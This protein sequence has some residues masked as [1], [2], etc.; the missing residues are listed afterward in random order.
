M[1]WRWAE[2]RNPICRIHIAL[3]IYMDHFRCYVCLF[4]IFHK[5]S[6]LF[7]L[8]F[9]V[10]DTGLCAGGTLY[11]SRT[12]NRFI[13]CICFIWGSVFLG[14]YTKYLLYLEYISHPLGFRIVPYSGYNMSSKGY[15][16]YLVNC[17]SFITRCYVSFSQVP[18]IFE[19]IR[20][21]WCTLSSLAAWAVISLGPFLRKESVETWLPTWA[22]CL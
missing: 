19:A 14:I 7:N 21:C 9:Q 17:N 12:I 10:E 6:L 16:G 2:R 13:S 3:K 8:I 20:V 22:S 15:S 4:Y 11:Q 1:T 18:N 5:P